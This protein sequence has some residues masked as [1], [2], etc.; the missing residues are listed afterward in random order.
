MTW[1]WWAPLVAASLHV[2]E[3]F[4]FPGG[5]AD[6]DR[7]YRPEINKSITPRFH[8]M[9]NA[10][11]ILVCVQVGR[12]APET[13]VAV[14]SAAAAAWLTVAALLFSNALFH[15]QGAIKTRRYS[16][17][18]ATGL[19]LYVPLA[20]FGYVYFLGTHRASVGTAAL[21]AFLGGSYHFWAALLHRRRAREQISQI[22]DT[23]AQETGS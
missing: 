19:F 21:A 22:D 23:E 1:I 8:L 14:R 9:V 3:E 10:L 17:G 6:W 20:I 12:L 7:A 4:V 5:F 13:S 18:I 2:F 15:L 11:L 16:P